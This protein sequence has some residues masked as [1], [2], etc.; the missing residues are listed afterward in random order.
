LPSEQ[1]QEPTISIHPHFHYPPNPNSLSP[2]VNA[3][4]IPVL[5]WCDGLTPIKEIDNMVSIYG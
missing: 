2:L 5:H 3:Q 1:L 4:C